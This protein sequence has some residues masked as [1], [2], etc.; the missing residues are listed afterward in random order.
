[1]VNR[2]GASTHTT[3]FN[4]RG[5][6]LVVGE[7]LFDVMPDGNRI[8]GGAPFNVAWHLQAFGLKPL[9]ITRVGDDDAGDEVVAAMESWGMDCSGVQ[10]DETLPTGR[11]EVELHGGEPTFHILP[12]Q[13]WDRLDGHLAKRTAAG[14]DCSLMYHGSLIAR[15]GTSRSALEV[16]K[17][18]TALPAIM[19][20]NLRDPWWARGDVLDMIGGA[21]WVKLNQDELAELAGAADLETAERFRVRH[22][23]DAV[24]VTRGGRG[25][26][27]IEQERTREAAPPA[28]IAVVDTVGA[29]DAFSAVYLLGLMKGWSTSATLERALEFAAAVCTRPGATTTDRRLYSDF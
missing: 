5:R 29:G 21:R 20:V 10:R 13:A 7:V 15:D 14:P 25:A 27:V 19:D 24:I 23:L 11:V 16:L 26:A 3:R 1:M 18:A 4:L 12:N 2:K 28:S 22:T 17:E 9:L 8:L 6:P